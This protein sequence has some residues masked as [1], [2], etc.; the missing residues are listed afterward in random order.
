MI[1]LA[2]ITLFLLLAGELEFYTMTLKNFAKMV[3]VQKTK[4]PLTVGSAGDLV[5]LYQSFVRISILS[6]ELAEHNL[7]YLM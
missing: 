1:L 4:V 6:K 7:I 5:G 2:N 3:M